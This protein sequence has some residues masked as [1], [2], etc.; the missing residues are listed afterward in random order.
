MRLSEAL[1][2]F[3]TEYI[4]MRGLSSSTLHNYRE[5]IQSATK[6]LGDIEVDVIT[7]H[8]VLKWRQAMEG[9][10]R[11]GTVR[12]NMSKLKNILS[13]T[14]RKGLTS[15]DMGEFFL[16][17]VPPP[18]PDYLTA[19]EVQ[20]LVDA[21]ERPRDKAL[22]SMLYTTG[23]RAGEATRLTKRDIN[24]LTVFIRQ[25]KCNTSRTVFMSEGTRQLLNAYLQTRTDNSDVIFYSRKFGQLKPGTINAELR[26][27]AKRTTITKAV[28]SHILRHSFATALVLGGVDISF[29]QRMLG[30]AFINTTMIYVHLT[31]ED[32]RVQHHKVFN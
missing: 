28:H 14:N 23:M 4:A 17:K 22:I 31:N 24:G 5:A 7:P 3:E 11:P 25:G 1:E 10:N 21:A 20:E 6:T 13:F 19:H 9:H 8:D 32:L 27:I 30:H 18:L 15:F 12:V 2:C 29:T 16:P 26:E